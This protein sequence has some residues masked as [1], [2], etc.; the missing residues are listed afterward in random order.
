MG[1]GPSVRVGAT[2]VDVEEQAGVGLD[3]APRQQGRG[4]GHEADA[5]RGPRVV[6]AGAV[7]R[8]GARRRL[9]EPADDAQQR[10]LAAA[11]RAEHG[12]D[13]ARLD[14]EVDRSQRLDRAEPLRDA[15]EL[16]G[17][18]HGAPSVRPTATER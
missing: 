17:G 3:R 12:H 11:G 10:R 9:D 18:R 14:G 13:L 8:H 1:V 4:L 16:D 6:R 7:D 5:L 15:H 2:A